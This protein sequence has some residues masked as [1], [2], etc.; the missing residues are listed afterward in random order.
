M[1]FS[2]IP[3]ER[4]DF[5]VLE[6]SFRELI[7]Q[8]NEAQSEEDKRE[9]RYAFYDLNDYVRTMRLIAGIRFDMDTSDDFYKEEKQYYSE[10]WPVYMK[11]RQ[12][13]YPKFRKVS[14]Q[15]SPVQAKGYDVNTGRTSL[16]KSMEDKL[17][18]LE[19]EE[20]CLVAGYDSIRLTA[21][22]VTAECNPESDIKAAW[23]RQLEILEK[24]EKQ[25]DE[26]YDGLVKN[27]TLWAKAKGYENYLEWYYHIQR[28][29]YGREEVESFR[30]QVKEYIVPLANKLYDRRR[31][32]LGTDKLLYY[33]RG[34]YFKEGNPAYGGSWDDFLSDC[35][36][37]YGEMSPETGEFFEFM[38]EHEL[39][40]LGWRPTKKHFSY[41]VYLPFHHAPFVFCGFQSDSCTSQ[42]LG[43]VFH[44]LGHAF[45]MY[46]CEE[47]PRSNDVGEINSLAMEF[48]ADK[49]ASLFFGARAQDHIDMHLEKAIDTILMHCMADE[50]EH[51]VYGNPNM[52]PDDRKAEWARLNLAYKPH[53]DYGDNRYLAGCDWQRYSRFYSRP[54]YEIDYGLATLCALQYKSMMEEDYKAAWGSYL[55]LSKI[56][57]SSSFPAAVEDTGLVNPFSEGCIKGLA[58]KISL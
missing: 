20:K 41:A 45:Q 42:E 1:K 51:I 56:S 6:A 53:P 52:T 19:K 25:L 57:G 47:G 54:L 12:E 26:I 7:L 46:L 44:E 11:L 36:T 14:K 23:D 37:M 55:K 34:R 21:E 2:D 38:L 49:W 24:N 50:F 31:Q 8:F 48:F 15:D 28:D 43:T 17:V 39:L 9:V 29:C 33:D 32:R 4:V 18:S 40:D 13:Y 35:R 5:T 58:D 10:Q 22:R 27:R 30:R 16:E 3:Y